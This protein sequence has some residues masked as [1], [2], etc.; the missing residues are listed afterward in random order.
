MEITIEYFDE[1]EN[2]NKTLI[3]NSELVKSSF[4]QKGCNLWIGTAGN[5]SQY[6][7]K[8][9]EATGD[10]QHY[11]YCRNLKIDQKARERFE[12]EFAF[13]M[14]YPFIA[15]IDK[16]VEAEI[17][18]ID[19]NTTEKIKAICL[20]EE[21]ISGKTLTDFYAR[22][23]KQEK[24]TMFGHM[25]Q[26]L[27]GMNYYTTVKI[28]DPLIHRD[29]KPD[30]ILITDE[31]QIKYIDFDWSHVDEGMGTR[32]EGEEIGGSPPYMHPDQKRK[33][34]KSFVGMDIYSLGLVFLY[35]LTGEN[36]RTV[37]KKDNKNDDYVLYRK[38]A[39]KD[40][41]RE[42]LEIIAKMIAEKRKQYCR[43]EDVLSDFRLFLRKNYPEIYSEIM[44]DMYEKY[45]LL[46]EYP[47]LC[48]KNIGLTI[49]VYQQNGYEMKFLQKDK[50]W[51]S[52]GEVYTG[53]FLKAYSN[54]QLNIF[55]AGNKIL[56]IF[57]MLNSQKGDIEMLP[58]DFAGEIFQR[59]T[60]IDGFRFVV[61]GIRR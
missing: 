17:T 10:R 15:Y 21:R 11:D 18:M 12:K 53:E 19:N 38:F 44:R 54:V 7:I 37:L 41:D 28:N 14:R 46:P 58:F 43:T 24:K 27:Y 13:R 55:R 2:R 59:E 61:K 60:I 25:L 35:M 20:L 26:L 33:N 39:G 23:H 57:R 56:L 36:Y 49:E 45:H 30:N 16:K 48:E 5:D 8:Y 52:N 6:F 42:L 51:L 9:I 32:P 40:T 50:Y 3:G 31:G 1:E 34:V 4:G 29:V 47:I 22:N